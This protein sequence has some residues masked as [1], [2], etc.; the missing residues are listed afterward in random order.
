MADQ[1]LKM[2]FVLIYLQQQQPNGGAAAGMLSLLL[3]LLLPGRSRD[4]N[5]R[6]NIVHMQSRLTPC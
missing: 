4:L 2:Q 6:N 3:L 5:C 1:L